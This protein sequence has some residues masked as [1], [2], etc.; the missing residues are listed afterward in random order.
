MDRRLIDAIEDHDRRLNK[1]ELK[2]IREIDMEIIRLMQDVQRFRTDLKKLEEMNMEELLGKQHVK[3]EELKLV[4][5]V[6]KL[7]TDITKR[8][9]DVAVKLL[10]LYEKTK[11]ELI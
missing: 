11:N 9:N 8:L 7:H 10:E 6:Y 2:I 4:A 1:E 5:Q 3:H